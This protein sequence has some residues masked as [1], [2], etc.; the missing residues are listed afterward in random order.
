MGE[1]NLSPMR[2]Q[3]KSREGGAKGKPL[4]I[5]ARVGRL[6]GDE[7]SSETLGTRLGRDVFSC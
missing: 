3:M 4:K 6:D 5:A 2:K 7:G 1:S